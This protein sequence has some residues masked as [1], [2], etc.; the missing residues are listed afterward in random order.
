MAKGTAKSPGT[1]ATT[2]A[3]DNPKGKPAAP[4]IKKK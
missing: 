2:A 3:T 4:P 1:T